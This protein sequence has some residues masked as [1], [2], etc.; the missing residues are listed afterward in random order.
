M[1]YWATASATSSARLYWESFGKPGLKL[2]ITVPTGVAVFPK[3]IIAP[4]RSWMA[5]RYTN[6]TH[7]NLMPQG[8][9]FAALEQPALFVG[10][11]RQFFGS[12]R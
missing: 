12:L 11:L 4:V 10:E 1:L 9:H 7:W 8:G 2:P 5:P 6:I 3:E